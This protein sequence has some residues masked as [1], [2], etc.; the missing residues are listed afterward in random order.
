V[1]DG[2][3]RI[4]ELID[5]IELNNTELRYEAADVELELEELQREI[6][7]AL[8]HVVPGQ[9]MQ[10]LVDDWASAD[11]FGGDPNLMQYSDALWLTREEFEA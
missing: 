5:S 11:F 9:R 4:E 6:P 7:P 2:A 1:S 8:R 10:Q 3:S